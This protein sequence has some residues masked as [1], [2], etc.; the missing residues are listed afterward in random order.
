MKI[1]SVLCCIRTCIIPTPLLDPIIGFVN[2]RPLMNSHHSCQRRGIEVIE[3]DKT[4]SVKL[5][6]TGDTS[7][8]VSVKCETVNKT[9]KP[10][11]DYKERYN[12]VTFEA[13]QTTTFCNV[14]IVDDDEFEEQEFFQLQLNHPL[15]RVLIN[16]T[17]KIFCILI[18]EDSRD[19]KLIYKLNVLFTS[20]SQNQ[21][22][23]S[24]EVMKLF[25][26]EVQITLFLFLF[27][28]LKTPSLLP[29]M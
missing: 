20:V 21:W 10:S 2:V 25:M 7:E 18:N 3:G 13:G 19:S 24:T 5:E 8:Q 4:I 9:A 26:S 23:I 27:F 1:V 16:Q 15:H 22:C 28:E 12:R 14:T 29:L 6:R 17:S 11:Q